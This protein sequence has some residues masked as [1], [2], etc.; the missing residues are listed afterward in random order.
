MAVIKYEEEYDVP[1]KDSGI[2]IEYITNML[3]DVCNLQYNKLR[4]EVIKMIKKNGLFY[5]AVKNA[6]TGDV[7]IW[8]IYTRKKNWNGIKYYIKC[9]YDGNVDIDCPI[10]LIDL[11]SPTNRDYVN[12]WRNKCREKAFK[13]KVKKFKIT[14]GKRYELIRDMRFQGLYSTIVLNTGD[15]VECVNAH[16]GTFKRLEIEEVDPVAKYMGFSKCSEYAFP[17]SGRDM[18]LKEAGAI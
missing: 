3:N 14:A 18:F 2:D 15:I 5:T 9:D 10:E 12:I 1:V 8:C 6:F 16:K 11:C 4:Y 13:P 7:G 17:K